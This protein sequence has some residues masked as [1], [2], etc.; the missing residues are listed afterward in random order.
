MRYIILKLKILFNF[1]NLAYRNIL[2][3]QKR[4]LMTIT[5]LSLGYTAFILLGG[6]LNWTLYALN[7]YTVYSQR[8]SHISIYKKGGLLKHSVNFSLYTFTPDEQKK[9]ESILKKRTDIEFFTA[10]FMAKGLV[11]NGCKTYPFSAV[12]IEPNVEYK[13]KHHREVKNWLPK[14][15]NFVKGKGIWEYSD[16]IGAITVATGLFNLLGKTKVYDEFKQDK[17][18]FDNSPVVIDCASKDVNTKFSEDANVQLLATDSSGSLSV[19][20]GEIVGVFNIG[21]KEE[22]NTA[23]VTSLKL[24]QNLYNTSNVS[25]YAI[26]LYPLYVF[27]FPFVMYELYQEFAKEQIEVDIYPWFSEQINPYF[28]GSINFLHTLVGF[29]FV[30]LSIVILFSVFNSVTITVIERSQEIGM[31]RSLGFSKQLVQ[32]V[33]WLESLFLTA[34]GIILGL[35]MSFLSIFIINKSSIPFSPPGIVEGLHLKIAPHFLIF[36]L[37]IALM[38]VLSSIATYL[39]V[40][41]VSRSRISTLLLKVNR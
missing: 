2:R 13:I 28:S 34:I 27:K 30:V 23:I 15:I 21:M 17:S 8:S 25:S 14:S 18:Q 19:I 40:F 31:L 3:N 32:G 5:V 37:F 16:D 9:I 6:Y 1:I 35:L 41:T 38:F 10:K 33:F 20:D 24:L 7:V 11:G 29:I 12:G 36:I 22:E 4:N 39:A 26:W